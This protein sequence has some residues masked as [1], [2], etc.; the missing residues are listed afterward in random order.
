MNELVSE[1]VCLPSALKTEG[2]RLLIVQKYFF[3]LSTFRRF[4]MKNRKTLKSSLKKRIDFYS[5]T[6]DKS[7]TAKEKKV[8]YLV[9]C[10]LSETV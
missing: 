3:T 9:L 4:V 10:Q 6:T 1:E 5:V 2:S 8:D 7:L